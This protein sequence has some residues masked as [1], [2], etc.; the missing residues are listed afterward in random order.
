MRTCRKTYEKT[1]KKVSSEVEAKKHFLNFE[2][3]LKNIVNGGASGP[4]VA[5]DNMV[6]GLTEI[7]QF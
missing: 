4:S 5:T 7:R 2:A 6:K 3:A 1:V